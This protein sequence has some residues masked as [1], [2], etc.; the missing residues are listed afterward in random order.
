[1]SEKL[2][3]EKG[4]EQLESASQGDLSGCPEM[5]ELF[6]GVSQ[7]I[8]QNEVEGPLTTTKSKPSNDPR[9]WWQDKAATS[10]SGHATGEGERGAELNRWGE[11]CGLCFLVFECFM[12]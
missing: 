1:V 9:R 12:T 5:L 4:W 11:R 7:G 6:N 10:T 2:D 3:R 8:I